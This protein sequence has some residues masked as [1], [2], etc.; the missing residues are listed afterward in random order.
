MSLE[1]NGFEFG[2]FLPDK[3]E[4]V[5]RREGKPPAVT[6]KAFERLPVPVEN[7]GHPVEKDEL[8]QAV[9]KDSF[10]EEDNLSFTGGK[11]TMAAFSP[12]AKTSVFA[13]GEKG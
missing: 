6:P 10:V 9:R 1:M 4:R 11:V 8:V 2:D 13:S 7:H 12:D 3:Q 5:L